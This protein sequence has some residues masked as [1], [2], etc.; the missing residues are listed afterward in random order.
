MAISTRSQFR[1][2][3][4][5][6]C[7]C[8]SEKSYRRGDS[9]ELRTKAPVLQEADWQSECDYLALRGCHCVLYTLFLRHTVPYDWAALINRGGAVFIPVYV[10]ISN[11][12]ELLSE[13]SLVSPKW[14]R[15]RCKFHRSHR[16]SLKYVMPLAP[17]R[18]IVL[19]LT[20]F[21]KDAVSEASE[22]SAH[23][24]LIFCLPYHFPKFEKWRKS[25][26]EYVSFFMEID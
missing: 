9:K 16:D 26:T 23:Q 17:A 1:V 22:N 24:R 13:A 4:I 6:K 15:H 5:H 18:R 11:Q 8:T 21:P 2:L 20:Q 25:S 10:L 19:C 14:R 12:P 7:V 3:C